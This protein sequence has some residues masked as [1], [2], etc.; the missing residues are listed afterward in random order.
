MVAYCGLGVSCTNGRLNDSV[1]YWLID[2]R[3]IEAFID[4]VN[5][6]LLLTHGNC[7]IKIGPIK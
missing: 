5:I 2:A 3:R 1:A 7:T 4:I 6:L